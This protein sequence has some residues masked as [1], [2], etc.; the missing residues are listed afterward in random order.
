MVMRI[1]FAS[2]PPWLFCNEAFEKAAQFAVVPA[3]LA[4]EL[5]PLPRLAWRYS[6]AIDQGPCRPISAP[7][8]ATQ[9][10][11]ATLL[12]PLNDAVALAA[13]AGT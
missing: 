10:V 4:V 11:E 9:P 7:A 6:A 3:Q 13:P 12:P 2:K 5:D 1:R 8:P